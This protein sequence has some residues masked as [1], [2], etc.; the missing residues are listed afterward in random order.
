MKIKS[1]F[2]E[3]FQLTKKNAL[4]LIGFFLLLFI[5]S[6]ITGTIA[7]IL[8]SQK[9]A[10][11][12]FTL[13]NWFIQFYMSVA[14][15]KLGF[16]VLNGREL[17]FAEIKPKFNELSKFMIAS[18]YIIVIAIG[19]LFLT[20]GLLT[21]L[22]VIDISFSNM[23]QDLSLNPKNIANYSNTEIGY[24]MAN[25]LLVFLPVF[26]VYLRLQFVGYLVIDQNLKISSAIIYSFRMTK[27]HLGSLLLIILCLLILNIIGLL[28]L[29][30]GLLFTIPMT[31]LV[32]VLCYKQLLFLD[33]QNNNSVEKVNY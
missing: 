21:L 27:G 1:I 16:Q 9:V 12:L 14:I 24:F 29:V 23:M 33:S 17:E 11:L 31:F 26:I 10:F 19:I 25:M 18:V 20:I 32:L 28:L 5:I 2:L 3:A 22:N 6:F 7:P 4:V 8:K 30:V 13:L 15:I